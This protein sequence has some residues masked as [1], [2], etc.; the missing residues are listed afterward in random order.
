[1]E[2][3]HCRDTQDWQGQKD[4]GS[5]GRRAL[6]WKLASNE[7]APTPIDSL[8]PTIL[9]IHEQINKANGLRNHFSALIL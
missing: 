1:M 6:R 3:G 2:T 5:P 8:P 9:A 4:T 7:I